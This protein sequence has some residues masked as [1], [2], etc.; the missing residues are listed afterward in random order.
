MSS[1]FPPQLIRTLIRKTRHLWSL[2][3]SF[4]WV[5]KVSEIELF[6]A[7]IPF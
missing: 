2:I 7:L 6:W 5:N 1:I 3:T 4:F